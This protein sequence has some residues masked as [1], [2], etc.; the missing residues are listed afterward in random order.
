MGVK[1]NCSY[2][3]VR[4]SAWGCCQ[5]FLDSDLSGGHVDGGVFWEGVGSPWSF[6]MPSDCMGLSV[7]IFR[8]P[9]TPVHIL[10]DFTPL[11]SVQREIPKLGEDGDQPFLVP[12]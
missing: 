10:G 5:G 6:G 8:L 12:V 4:G 2:P 11:A 9:I 1:Q 7:G 3:I